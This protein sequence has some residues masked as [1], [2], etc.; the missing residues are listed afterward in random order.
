MFLFV[1][2]KKSYACLITSS[3]SDT[4]ATQDAIVLIK[5]L[6]ENGNLIDHVFF[7]CEGRKEE[8]N[9][10]PFFGR[11][12]FRPNYETNCVFLLSVLQ[13]A[14]S[15]VISHTGAPFHRS[16]L[17]SRDLCV[18]SGMTLL[19]V[20]VCISGKMP[21]VANFLQV[22]PLPSQNAKLVFLGKGAGDAVMAPALAP[23]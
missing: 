3:P 18:A 23:G 16:I 12:P 17:E 1:K 7:Y 21:E 11:P 15:A 22:K 6:L 8:T 10:N 9:P 20:V 4:L 19:F 14:I 13:S 5:Q 2:M